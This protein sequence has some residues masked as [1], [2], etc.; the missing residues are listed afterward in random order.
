M[1]VLYLV[2]H[3]QGS[4]GTDNYDRL[5]EVGREQCRLLGLHFAE[6]GER[7]DALYAGTLMRQRET[8][9]LIALG[10]AGAGGERLPVQQDPAFNEYEGD[11][12]L[13]AFAASL[14]EADLAAAGWPALQKDRRRFQL[15]LEQAAGAWVD[16]QLLAN[17]SH[18][19]QAFHGRVIEALI[20][21]M[22][23]EGRGKN[24]VLSTSGGVIG[25][26]VAHVLGAS[27]RTGIEL[28]W[29]VHNASVTRLI[30]SEQK[31]SLSMFNALPH[32]EQPERR[33]LITYR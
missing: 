6:Q 29:A 21:I 25:I 3:G 12:I 1:S 13:K 28:N 24:V 9:D 23:R 30:Y 20:G 14:S 33:K 32:L 15:F 31:V 18:A 16:G 5:S 27:N 8:A 4:F 11:V 26:I 22:R 17:G 7:I 19:F 10:L 2:R